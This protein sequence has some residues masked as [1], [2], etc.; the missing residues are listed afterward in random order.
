MTKPLNGK[1]KIV[2]S[3][4][5]CNDAKQQC[6]LTSV[7]ATTVA[8]QLALDSGSATQTAATA[9]SSNSA[10]AP[11]KVAASGERVPRLCI[12]PVPKES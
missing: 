11:S 6:Y 1:R 9:T 8:R 2:S 7:V 10:N 3:P 5:R 12:A 4:S